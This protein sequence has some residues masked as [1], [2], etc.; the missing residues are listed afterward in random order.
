MKQPSTRA[1][2]V[3]GEEEK[4]NDKNQGKEKLFFRRRGEQV[5]AVSSKT[6]RMRL[7]SF[8]SL[9][10]SPALFFFPP[11]GLVLL[12][13]LGSVLSVCLPALLQSGVIISKVLLNPSSAQHQDVFC[14]LIP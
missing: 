7:F 9:F 3:S 5:A 4:K 14:M 2:Y 1:A 10:F 11:S 12:G 6:V 8:L 13:F